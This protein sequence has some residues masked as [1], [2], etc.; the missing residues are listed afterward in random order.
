MADDNSNKGNTDLPTYVTATPVERGKISDQ[1]QFDSPC[2]KRPRNSNPFIDILG[3]NLT[4]LTPSVK[5]RKLILPC[6]DNY[7]I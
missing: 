1:E 4:N 7:L 2:A 6:Y 3:S 5:V